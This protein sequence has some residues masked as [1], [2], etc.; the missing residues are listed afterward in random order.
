MLGK[1]RLT[2]L[3]EIFAA[4]SLYDSLGYRFST[5]SSDRLEGV[6]DLP[7]GSKKARMFKGALLR[8]MRVLGSS[9]GVPRLCRATDLAS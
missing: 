2:V 3:K 6:L 4:M 5:T 7:D 1:F 9:A 8:S